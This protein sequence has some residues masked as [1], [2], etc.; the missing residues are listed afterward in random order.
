MLWK[1]LLITKFEN[2]FRILKKSDPDD[3]FYNREE[4]WFFKDERDAQMFALKYGENPS[5][6]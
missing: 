2:G 5:N 3:K 1:D 4:R 6:H